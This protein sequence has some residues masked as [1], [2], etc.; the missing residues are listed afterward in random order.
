[1]TFGKVVPRPAA[2]AIGGAG[3]GFGAEP[4]PAVA[5]PAPSQNSHPPESELR[6]FA[7]LKRDIVRLLGILCDHDTFVQDRVR[8]CG[9]IPVIM[10]MCVVDDQNPCA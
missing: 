5:P 10:N 7:Y 1:M 4:Q 3:K 2:S 6:G 9:G 8:D